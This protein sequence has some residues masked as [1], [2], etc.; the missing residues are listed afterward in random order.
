MTVSD[1]ICLLNQQSAQVV[2]IVLIL[3]IFVKVYMYCYNKKFAKITDSETLKAVA[4]DCISDSAA[5]G[6]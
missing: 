2:V 1:I 3:S 4:A 5:A 6:G